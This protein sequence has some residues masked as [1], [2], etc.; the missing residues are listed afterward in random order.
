MQPIRLK[1]DDKQL[2]RTALALLDSA[3]WSG[4]VALVREQPPQG[5]YATVQLLANAAPVTADHRP[6][7]AKGGALELT[8]AGA[9]LYGR[10][11][12]FRGLDT[13]EHISDDQWELYLP[14]LAHAQELLA[15][16][17]ALDPELGLAAA[18]RVTA[19]VDA[20]EEEKDEAE[21]ALRRAR[22]VPIAGLV[23][24]ITMRS[25]KW[26]GSHAA[27]WRVA[28][29]YADPDNPASLSLIAKA[30]FE[31]WLWLDTFD[32][33]ADALDKADAYFHDGQVQEE[34]RQASRRVLDADTQSD[35]RAILFADNAFAA[36]FW[37]GGDSRHA[38]PHLQ[39]M[40]RSID[41]NLW[42][43]NNPR[44][45][46]NRARLSAWLLPV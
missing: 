14:T 45:T 11:M 41:R 24:L 32:E 23:R 30:H 3:D 31:Q 15:E 18:W 37:S 6:L 42:L 8:L 40:G 25:E 22:S 39:R 5:A 21:L 7:V 19:F 27:M 16:A 28:S 35:P 26:G 33:A 44:L 38:K 10:A 36:T 4:L 17:N 29:D 2:Q 46:V 1:P 20:T 13:A 12:R 34:L 9:L 43:F